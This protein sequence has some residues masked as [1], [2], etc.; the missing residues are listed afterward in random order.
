M[1]GI[2]RHTVNGG[3]VNGGTTVLRSNLEESSSLGKPPTRIPQVALGVLQVELGS[4]SS[5]KLESGKSSNSQVGEF[6][7]LESLQ[8]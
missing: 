1:H 3:T 2:W 8:A 6:P 5:N 4:L 7:K